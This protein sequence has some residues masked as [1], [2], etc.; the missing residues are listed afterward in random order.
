MNT[1]QREK[2]KPSLGLAAF[3]SHLIL[4]SL[5]PEAD[6]GQAGGIADD[7]RRGSSPLHLSDLRWQGASGSAASGGAGVVRWSWSRG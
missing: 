3:P 6:V 7:G 4:L 2:K 5:S 1:K